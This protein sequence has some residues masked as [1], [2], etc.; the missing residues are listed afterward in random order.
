M[1]ELKYDYGPEFHA[2][3]QEVASL[4]GISTEDLIGLIITESIDGATNRAGGAVGLFQFLKSSLS[5][6]GFNGTPEQFANLPGDKQIDYFKKI[7]QDHLLKN[8]GGKFSSGGHFYAAHFLPASCQLLDVKS[9][10]PDAIIAEINP[11]TVEINGKQYSKKYYEGSHILI[12][13][14]TESSW[15]KSNPALRDGDKITI[16]SMQNIIDRNKNSDAAKKL[17]SKI[18]MPYDSVKTTDKSMTKPSPTV[19]QESAYNDI[20]RDVKDF[21]KGIEEIG[22]ESGENKYKDLSDIRALKENNFIVKVSS[23]DFCSSV[24]FAR[25]LSEAYDDILLAHADTHID[26]KNVEIEC[27]VHG[28][29]YLCYRAAEQ[30]TKVIKNAFVNST[31]IN[32][33]ELKFEENKKSSLQ[34]IDIKKAEIEYRKFLIKHAR[35]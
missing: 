2:K 9:G 11:P 31:N 23:D 20:D 14:E 16:R 29:T 3:L 26:D 12:T 25:V 22:A 32:N 21:Y 27:T 15:V 35:K 30:V 1:P 18:D 7:V 10:D 4:A 6:I 17:M 28:P 13:P 8:N 24:E 33:L 34:P 19:Q 5:S